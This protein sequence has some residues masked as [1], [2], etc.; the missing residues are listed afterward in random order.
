VR[1]PKTKQII[2]HDY[3]VPNPAMRRKILAAR[4]DP[5]LSRAL[6]AAYMTDNIRQVARRVPGRSLK[7]AWTDTDLYMTHRF[8]ATGT[9]NVLWALEQN[10]RARFADIVGQNVCD[11]NPNLCGSKPNKP[12][13]VAQAYAKLGQKLA[14]APEMRPD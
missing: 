2:R 6:T 4:Q 12:Y 1:D 5:W 3:D 10:P 13:S 8:G 11:T 7:K 14:T 9:A